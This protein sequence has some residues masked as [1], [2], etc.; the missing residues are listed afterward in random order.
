MKLL[1]VIE[2]VLET[3]QNEPFISLSVGNDG[4][5]KT[6]TGLML[7]ETYSSTSLAFLSFARA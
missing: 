3:S 5:T 6:A 1:C 4:L 2:T 7:L